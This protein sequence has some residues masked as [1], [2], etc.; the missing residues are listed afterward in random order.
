VLLDAAKGKDKEVF[1]NSDSSGAIELQEADKVEITTIIDNYTDVLLE[2]TDTVVRA[3]LAAGEYIADAPLTIP[4]IL[5]R[6]SS[7]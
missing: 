4:A 7:C 1:M 3:P 2:S 5:L 6:I